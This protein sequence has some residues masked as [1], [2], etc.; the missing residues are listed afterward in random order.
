MEQPLQNDFTLLK[1]IFAPFREIL[2]ATFENWKF[3]RISNIDSSEAPSKSS[4]ADLTVYT[5][6]MHSEEGVEPQYEKGAAGFPS[7]TST[8]LR[9]SVLKLEACD[10]SV[11]TFL[12]RVADPLQPV[13]AQVEW[14]EVHVSPRIMIRYYNQTLDSPIHSVFCTTTKTGE[15]FCL[16][17][18]QWN[19]LATMILSG[20]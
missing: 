7:E 12:S 9:R 10:L 11:N 15:Q 20:L 19:S 13:G 1:S 4:C 14:L 18:S 6:H 16:P 17:T 8:E 2:G 3:K 5:I